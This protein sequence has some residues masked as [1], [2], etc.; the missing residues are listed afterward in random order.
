MGLVTGKVAVKEIFERFEH[1]HN[2]EE[3]SEMN[4][5]H[6]NDTFFV[7]TDGDEDYVLQRIVRA[8]KSIC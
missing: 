8:R 3:H 1:Q 7:K 6:I 2:Y 4:S 5:G